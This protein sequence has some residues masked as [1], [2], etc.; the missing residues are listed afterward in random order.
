LDE[1][2]EKKKHC[3]SYCGGVYYCIGCWSFIIPSSNYQTPLNSPYSLPTAQADISNPQTPLKQ[4]Q[5]IKIDAASLLPDGVKVQE[6]ANGITINVDMN[7]G[8]DGN[9]SNGD[10]V[11]SIQAQFQPD[12][13]IPLVD[14]IKICLLFGIFI[15]VI[16][17]PGS[18]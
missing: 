4:E 5:T 2:K 10:N 1:Q 16:R 13:G 9:N 6:D 18:K 12:N 15:C 8:S 3:N 7:V 14:V 17:K 11:E